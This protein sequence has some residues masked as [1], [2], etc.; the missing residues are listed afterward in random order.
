M[1]LQQL[2]CNQKGNHRQGL[3]TLLCLHRADQAGFSG[4]GR[5]FASLPPAPTPS[6]RYLR[7]GNHCCV[8]EAGAAGDLPHLP[9][10]LSKLLNENPNTPCHLLRSSHQ[11]TYK[12]TWGWASVARNSWKFQHVLRIRH[13]RAGNWK[14]FQWHGASLQ[15]A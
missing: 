14:V 7:A 9:S 15:L 10:V 6:P 12:T 4:L 1:V 13:W 8:E 3:A 11:V 5:S 2:F